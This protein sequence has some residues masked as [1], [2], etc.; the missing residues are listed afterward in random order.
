[1]SFQLTF[2]PCVNFRSA[3]MHNYQVWKRVRILEVRSENGCGKWHEIGSGFE[4]PGGTPPPRIPRSTPPP[5][6]EFSFVKRNEWKRKTLAS[7]PFMQRSICIKKVWKNSGLNGIQFTQKKI[8]HFSLKDGPQNFTVALEA[9]LLSHV[10][11]F[12]TIFQPLA[13]S[14]N[15]QATWRGLFTKYLQF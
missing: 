6:G 8:K 15:I 12:Q 10:F 4:D 11:I 9:L 2:T 14:S 1:M 3:L 13:L 7:K 5:P